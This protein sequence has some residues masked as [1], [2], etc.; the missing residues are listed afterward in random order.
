MSETSGENEDLRQTLKAGL[1]VYTANFPLVTL[2]KYVFAAGLTSTVT[3][4]V[5]RMEQP[6]PMLPQV[7]MLPYEFQALRVVG[8]PSL[9]R[10]WQVA[11]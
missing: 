5:A 1:F 2:L 7:F 9:E 4:A 10:L 8:Q 11:S 3:A 6:K